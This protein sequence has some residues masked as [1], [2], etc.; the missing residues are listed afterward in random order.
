MLDEMPI[1]EPRGK[2]TKFK[3]VLISFLLIGMVFLFILFAIGALM[4]GGFG[5]S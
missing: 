5:R 4:N 3:K 2:P 1:E